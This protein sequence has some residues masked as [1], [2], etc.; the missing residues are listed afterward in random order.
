MEFTTRNAGDV[1]V[2][3]LKGR[4]SSS[5]IPEVGGWLDSTTANPNVKLLVNLTAVTFIDSSAL[6]VLIK[7]LKRCRQ[8]SGELFLCGVEGPVRVIFELTRLDKAFSIYKDEA[9]ALAAFN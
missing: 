1:Y 7:G 5:E 9:E 3:D 2:L 4:F 8:Q 6:A